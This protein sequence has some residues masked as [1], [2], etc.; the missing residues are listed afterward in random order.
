MPEDLAH[1]FFVLSESAYFL[2]KRTSYYHPTSKQI[3]LWSDPVLENNWPL[4]RIKPQLAAKDAV[5]ALLKIAEVF[6]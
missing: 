5:G 1:G 3:L 4:D 2:Y 6:I